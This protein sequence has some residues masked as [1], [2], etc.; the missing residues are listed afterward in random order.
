MPCS[1]IANHNSSSDCEINCASAVT[2]MKCYPP[3]RHEVR[4]ST[5][6][7]APVTRLRFIDIEAPPGS[8]RGNL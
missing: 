1:T 3:T 2:G 4:G 8:P 6:K 5:D 7:L